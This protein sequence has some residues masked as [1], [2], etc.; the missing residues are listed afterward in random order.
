MPKRSVGLIPCVECGDMKSIGRKLC[1]LC[2]NRHR[3]AGTLSRFDKLTPADTFL[4]RVEK[5]SSC[6]LWLGARN[7]YGYGIVLL[8]GEVKVRAH[9]FAHE[10]FCGPIPEGMVV[11]HV[12]DNPPCVNPAHLELGTKAENNRDTAIRR[13]HH[14]GRDHW[15]GRLT[16][17]DVLEILTSPMRNCEL[18]RKFG[19]DPSHISRLRS[20]NR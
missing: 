8:P 6:W 5:T 13:R 3:K 17:G 20:G 9:R 10:L 18:A 19:V 7:Q 12:C 16:E 15:N 11:R 1:R 2:Y 4:T 14:Y